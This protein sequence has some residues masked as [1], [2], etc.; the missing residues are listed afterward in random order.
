[1]KISGIEQ[2]RRAARDIRNIPSASQRAGYRAVNTVLGKV[3]TQSRRYIAGQIN[4]PQSYIRELTRT[5]KASQNST[6]AYIRMRIRAVRL[7]RFDARQL[8]TPAPR[9]KGDPRRGIPAGRKRAGVSVKVG[10]KGGRKI[11][12]GA[13]LM[14]L[15]AGAIGGANGMGVFVRDAGGLRHRYGPSPDQI[16]RRWRSEAAP[17]I[18]AMLAQAYISQLRYELKGSRK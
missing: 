5:T 7:A 4:L 15:R 11:M 14:P 3:E 12:R 16:F 8:T 1:M 10:R 6:A 9:A 2:L 18:R 17:D 13:F